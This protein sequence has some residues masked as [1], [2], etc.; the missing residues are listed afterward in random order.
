V[1]TVFKEEGCN[2]SENKTPPFPVNKYLDILNL[3]Q[4]DRL[5]YRELFRKEEWQ[6]KVDRERTTALNSPQTYCFI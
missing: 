1:I 2:V 4:R 6:G 3:N 5:Q